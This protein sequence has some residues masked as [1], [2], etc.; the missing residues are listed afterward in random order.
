MRRSRDMDAGIVRTSLYPLAAATKA[1]A[2]PVLPDVGST[3]V[4]LP[5]E[6]RPFCS[7]SSIMARPMRSLTEQHG[8]MI[9]SC[10]CFFVGVVGRKGLARVVF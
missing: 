8:S 3:S 9:S 7:A 1:R 6:M 4:V 5:G 10:F 2:M